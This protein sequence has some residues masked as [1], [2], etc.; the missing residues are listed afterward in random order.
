MADDAVKTTTDD[1]S[2]EDM[3][4]LRRRLMEDLQLVDLSPEQQ[5]EFEEK[6]D[7]LVDNRI[8][9]MMLV[10]LPQEKV[11][12]LSEMW[13]EG[14]EEE[15]QKF[16]EENVEGWNDK[17]LDEFFAIREELIAKMRNHA[18]PSDDNQ[19]AV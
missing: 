10:Y 15:I 2:T 12:E 18:K 4:I 9:N 7:T 1:N 5:K 3:K 16:L 17:V 13:D 8:K 11:K 14:K 6:I 19:P